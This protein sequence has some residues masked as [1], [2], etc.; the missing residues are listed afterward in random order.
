V[1]GE[2]A[3]CDPG[4]RT[5]NHH[6][7]SRGPSPR[8]RDVLITRFKSHLPPRVVVATAFDTR[9]LP[10][11]LF[12]PAV[13]NSCSPR[14]PDIDNPVLLER[15]A[16][17]PSQ[18]PLTAAIKEKGN[19]ARFRVVNDLTPQVV[20]GIRVGTILRLPAV[21]TS[22]TCQEVRRLLV[23]GEPRAKQVPPTTDPGT[24]FVTQWSTLAQSPPSDI[25]E[26]LT[27]ATDPNRARRASRPL[28][29]PYAPSGFFGMCQGG[30]VGRT[31]HALVPGASDRPPSRVMCC[32][33]LGDN[34]ACKSTL[35]KII[36]GVSHRNDGEIRVAGNH[37]ASAVPRLPARLAC[38]PS[39]Q[40]CA[41][42]DVLDFSPPNPT[43]SSAFPA[44]RL[45]RDPRAMEAQSAGFPSKEAPGHRASVGTEIGML[46]GDSPDRRDRPSHA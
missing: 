5:R 18:P 44:T 17:S 3:A 37:V 7:V 24:T 21:S 38:L 46:S 42:V 23:V 25:S 45:S 14:T 16:A 4:G 29:C 33:S 1:A 8:Y 40:I 43:C 11:T 13:R 6:Q 27:D 35:I 28:S 2:H 15:T 31:A 22:A 12:P 34:C 39:F 41:L 20:D 9:P 10:K 26:S 32:P 19:V 36:S 30:V